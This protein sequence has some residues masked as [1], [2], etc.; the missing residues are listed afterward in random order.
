MHELWDEN[1]QRGYEWWIMTEAMKVFFLNF[2][3]CTNCV[4]LIMLDLLEELL[5]SIDFSLFVLVEY[6]HSEPRTC[7]A[8]VLS[9]FFCF[10]FLTSQ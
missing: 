6:D 9:I 1:Y 4:G 2:I 8:P 10:Q 3:L 5:L 7:C